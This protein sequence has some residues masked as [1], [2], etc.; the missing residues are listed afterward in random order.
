MDSNRTLQKGN[1]NKGNLLF[2]VSGKNQLGQ[3]GVPHDTSNKRCF[4][5][6]EENLPCD[7]EDIA[8]VCCGKEHTLLLTKSHILYACGSNKNDQIG[9]DRG[10]TEN[11]NI[12]SFTRIDKLLGSEIVDIDTYSLFTLFLSKSG[13]VYGVGQ[14][15]SFQLG[16]SHT[17]KVYEPVLIQTLSKHQIIQCAV[18]ENHSLFLTNENK[19]FGCGSNND[20]QLGVGCNFRGNIISPIELQLHGSEQGIKSIHAG[21][22]HSVFVTMDDSVLVCGSNVYGQCGVDDFGHLFS[23]RFLKVGDQFLKAK[24]SKLWWQTYHNSRSK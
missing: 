13:L 16:L 21:A 10:C 5:V 9:V 15:D 17:K 11:S 22:N 2:M 23:T 19:V 14:N 20:G 3:C 8:K 24:K 12:H 1:S 6:Q 18:G 4:V 7:M